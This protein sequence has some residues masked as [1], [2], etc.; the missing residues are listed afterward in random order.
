MTKKNMEI[1][2]KT[3]SKETCKHDCNI[4]CNEHKNGNTTTSDDGA[5]GKDDQQVEITDFNPIYPYYKAEPLIKITL[6]KKGKKEV[7]EA[8]LS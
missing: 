5:E 4:P 6:V 1:A 2:N 7:K 8:K 3:M